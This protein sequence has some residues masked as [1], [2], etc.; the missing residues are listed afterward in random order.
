MNSR[1]ACAVAVLAAVGS[2]GTL[3]A[4][5]GGGLAGNQVVVHVEDNRDIAGA[6]AVAQQ[7]CAH[8]GGGQARMIAF[9]SANRGGGGR[10]DSPDPQPPDAIFQCDPAR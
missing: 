10:F 3:A 6:T 2:V 1:I 9:V 4:C 7:T 8:R 5:S